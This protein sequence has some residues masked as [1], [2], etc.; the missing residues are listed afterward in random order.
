MPVPF[1]AGGASA[2]A[3][4][5][6][7]TCEARPVVRFVYGLAMTETTDDEHEE[8]RLS[9]PQWRV[10]E[11]EV[12]R[13]HA[14]MD[15]S[16]QVQHDVNLVGRHS[17]RNRQVD[18]LIEGQ[19][20]GEKLRIAIECKRYARKLGI[21]GVDEFAGKLQD[22]NVE[23]GLLFTV[24]GFTEPAQRRAE[25]SGVPSIQLRQLDELARHPVNIEELRNPKF[26]DCPNDNC[27]TGDVQWIELASTAGEKLSVG[28]CDTCGT[29][30]VRC[31]ECN[32]IIA[33]DDERC[34]IA[35]YSSITVPGEPEW[36]SVVRGLEGRDTVFE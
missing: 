36:E 32:E 1:R 8:I 10:F 2:Y 27:Y 4:S 19:I 13:I 30:A 31:T 16:A 15:P 33:L 23:R 35:E 21:G 9:E 14:E 26:G 11:R 3:F 34:C 29:S 25:G 22:L 20:A 17:G 6:S 5:S 28:R 12:A 24:R 7:R 18:V